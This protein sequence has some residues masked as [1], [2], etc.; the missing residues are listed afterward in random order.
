MSAPTWIRATLS[1][2][3]ALPWL[4]ERIAISICDFGGGNALVKRGSAQPRPRVWVA[5]GWYKFIEK[6]GERKGEL[7][8]AEVKPSVKGAI[9]TASVYRPLIRIKAGRRDHAR[10]A[11]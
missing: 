2:M 5:A 3:E 9:Q 10:E 11:A 6:L 8:V 4:P 1:E 7:R